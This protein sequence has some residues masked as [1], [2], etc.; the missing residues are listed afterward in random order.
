M[1]QHDALPLGTASRI[2]LA[3]RAHGEAVEVIQR[4]TTSLDV[5]FTRL[6]LARERMEDEGVNATMVL[7]DWLREA[8][9]HWRTARDLGERDRDQAARMAAAA[10]RPVEHVPS[11]EPGWTPDP[12]D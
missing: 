7:P 12:R 1:N 3:H 10:A 5:A 4:L 11:P 9:T 2:E 6:E 8:Y